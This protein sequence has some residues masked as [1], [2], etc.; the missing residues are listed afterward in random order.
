V[1]FYLTVFLAAGL[2][3]GLSCA[4]APQTG[5][6][7]N[8]NFRSFIS[9]DTM[10]LA[11]FHL[12]ELKAAP[13]YQRHQDQLKFA[14]LDELA[15][16]IGLDP[17]RDLS[18]LLVAYNGKH[19]TVLARGTFNAADLQKKLVNLGARRAEYKQNPLF[20][21]R[22]QAVAFVG[23]HRALAG[24][25]DAVQAS[26]DLHDN[27]NGN[28]PEELQQ[29]LQAIPSRDQVWAVTRGGLPF[30]QMSSRSD[31]QS[32]LSNIADSIS[33]TSAGIGVDTGLHLRAEIV[34]ISDQ[35][36]QRVRDALRGAIGLGR[37][38]TKENE[39]DLLR[40]Y[41][42][43]QVQQNQRTVHVSSDLS[44]ELADELLTLVT[45]ASTYR[46]R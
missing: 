6:S 16:R 8:S 18:D 32:A 41:D 9:P 25:L 27:G 45:K 1:R 38:T 31:L 40:L 29:R 42:S 15:D 10:L 23:N 33:G 37:L 26:I 43:V 19:A 4:T 20:V 28:I 12:S 35:G 24:P 13:F 22:E 7:V 30:L 36:A 17:R 3:G 39:A 34:C 14:Q 2:V 11:G 21:S 5:I 44:P 46:P